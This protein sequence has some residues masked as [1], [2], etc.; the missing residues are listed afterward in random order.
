MLVANLDAHLGVRLQVAVLHRMLSAAAVAQGGWILV[1]DP[2]FGLLDCAAHPNRH[3]HPTCCTRSSHDG[4]QPLPCRHE[5]A[6]DLV[7]AVVLH[8]GA[9][10]ADRELHG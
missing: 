5:T 7:A 3:E 8:P 6:A 1:E 9:V 4:R 2:H 10:G